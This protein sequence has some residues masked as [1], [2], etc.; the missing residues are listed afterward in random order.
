MAFVSGLAV[1]LVVGLVAVVIVYL[2][3]KYI[4]REL[5]EKIESLQDIL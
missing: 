5:Q 3:R 4:E 1:G 2:R